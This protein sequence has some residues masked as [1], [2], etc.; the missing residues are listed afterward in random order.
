MVCDFMTNM[1]S[2]IFLLLVY[3]VENDKFYIRSSSKSK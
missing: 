3:F 1:N 2:L